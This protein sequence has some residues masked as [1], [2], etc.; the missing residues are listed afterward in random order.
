[1]KKTEG[2]PMK[3]N[4]R[5]EV[6]LYMA[7]ELS[8]NKWK[9]GFSDGNKMRFKSIEARNLEQLQDEIEKAKIRFYLD[10]DVRIVSCYEA[11]RDGFWFHRYLL[12]YE[13]E[14][15]VVDALWDWG[16]ELLGFC[17]GDV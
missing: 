14:N 10:D 8:Q 4:T 13:I 5:K 11:G 17:D 6:A 7:L 3:E 15:I 16:E 12:S 1:M 2:T 9:L